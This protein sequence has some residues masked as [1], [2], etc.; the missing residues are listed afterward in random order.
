MEVSLPVNSPLVVVRSYDCPNAEWLINSRGELV[1]GESPIKWIMLMVPQN[2]GI[3]QV[4][5]RQ[6]SK[7]FQRKFP[8]D[9]ATV[10]SD[11]E[12]T[13]QRSALLYMY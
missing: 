7:S 11:K 1:G 12:L 13:L 4:E 3:K 5:K 9:I 2:F 6:I 8:K 10:R